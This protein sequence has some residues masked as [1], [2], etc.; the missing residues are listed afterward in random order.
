MKRKL[1]GPTADYD[2]KLFHANL[3]EAALKA[4]FRVGCAPLQAAAFPASLTAQPGSTLMRSSVSPNGD[5]C[6]AAF[7]M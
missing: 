3:A 5:S 1:K 4:N 6:V 2:L 7:C